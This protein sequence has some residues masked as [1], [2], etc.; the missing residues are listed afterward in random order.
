MGSRKRLVSLAS[1]PATVATFS[2][3]L[4][5]Y[6]SGRHFVNPSLITMSRRTIA[7][8]HVGTGFFL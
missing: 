1:T 4:D 3:G 5:P 7:A 6:F 8:P 2:D